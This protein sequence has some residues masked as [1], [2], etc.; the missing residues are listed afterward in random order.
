MTNYPLQIVGL[1]PISTSREDEAER[2]GPQRDVQWG[3]PIFRAPVLP[4]PHQ[5]HGELPF[6]ANLPRQFRTR[7]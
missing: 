7:S 2:A 3:T 1:V 6:T 4:T 5:I